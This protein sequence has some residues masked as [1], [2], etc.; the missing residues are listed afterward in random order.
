VVHHPLTALLRA[1]EEAIHLLPVVVEEIDAGEARVGV[2]AT[3]AIDLLA[4]DAGVLGLRR[5]LVEGCDPEAE[6]IVGLAV[7]RHR[8][9]EMSRS[10]Q[11]CCNLL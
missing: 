6:V 2:E 9:E 8:E 11:F 7:D 1:A 3:V 4:V 10:V 5:R